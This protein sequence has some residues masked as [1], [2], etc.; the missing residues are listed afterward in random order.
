MEAGSGDFREYSDSADA[1]NCPEGL[2]R[3]E[4]TMRRIRV[5]HRSLIL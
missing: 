2:V 3:V 1:F 4:L 5:W